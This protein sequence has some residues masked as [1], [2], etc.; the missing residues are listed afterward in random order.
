MEVRH[1][2]SGVWASVR[3]HSAQTACSYV[4]HKPGEGLLSGPLI[5]LPD[6]TQRE[7]LVEGQRD[8]VGLVAL[9][10]PLTRQLV[11][12]FFWMCKET[13]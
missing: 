6:D 1:S 11:G 5:D 8:A 13:S 10:L 9:P 12:V 2:S 7:A 4:E 3:C